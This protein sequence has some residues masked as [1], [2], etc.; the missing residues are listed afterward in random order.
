[1]THK[2]Q[3][4]KAPR[5]RGLKVIFLGA[6]KILSKLGAQKRPKRRKSGVVPVDNWGEEM[7]W[8]RRCKEK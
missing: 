4:R 3:K 1:M 7:V 8:G 5:K 2:K 6:G